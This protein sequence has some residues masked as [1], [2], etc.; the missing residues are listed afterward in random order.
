[1][2][3]F[4]GTRLLA[5][6]ASGWMVSCTVGKDGAS[7]APGVPCNGCVNSAS[8]AP[9]AVTGAAIQD[10]AIQTPQLGAKSVTGAIIADA[11]ITST[12]IANATIGG[13]N[14]DPTTT[15][16]ASSFTFST[17]VG[18]VFF[19]DPALCQ[20]GESG[21]APYQDVQTLHPIGN[22]FGPSV[23]ISNLTAGV[24][25]FYCPVM[26]RIPNGALG[27]TITSASMAYFDTS[28]NCLVG[29]ELR[30]KIMASNSNGT[31]ASTVFDGTSSSDFAFTVAGPT[32]KAFPAFSLPVSLVT[33]VWI[34]T[35]IQIQNPA[36]SVEDCRYS[37]A[38]IGYTVD[39][40]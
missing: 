6:A 21:I 24:Y 31:V 22:S 9:G 17:P 28:L 29:A 35:I 27:V 13:A 7:G 26:L 36:A 4:Q 11:T 12:N 8:L 34:R 33:L 20:R 19:A 5:L 14:I 2:N 16:N 15:V 40:P 10:G 38:L 3:R 23:R 30:S 32:T 18:A 25:S 37:G 39:R 1:M